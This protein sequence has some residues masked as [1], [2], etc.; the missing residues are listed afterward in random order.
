MNHPLTSSR[1]AA[2]VDHAGMMLV[3]SVMTASNL[4]GESWKIMN[5]QHAM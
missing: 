2:F 4:G 3:R 1:R 5:T